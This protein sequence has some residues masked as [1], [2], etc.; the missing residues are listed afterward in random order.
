MAENC[1]KAADLVRVGDSSFKRGDYDEA[2]SSYSKAIR[3]CKASASKATRLVLAD[4]YNG[5]GHTLRSKGRFKEAYIS[6]KRALGIYTEGY[7]TGSNLDKRMAMA[8]HYTADVLADLNRIDES[9][10]LSRKELSIER[11]LYSHDRKNLFY[12]VYGLNNTACRFADKNDF[13]GAIRLLNESLKLQGRVASHDG[14]KDYPDLSWTYHI[15]GV[16]LLNMGDID[17]AIVTLRKSLGMRFVIADRNKR[18]IG[19][20]RNTLENLSIAYSRK[21][22]TQSKSGRGYL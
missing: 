18:F 15:L 14:K 21:G 9:L 4:A 13:K 8:L 17:G 16:T 22:A 2:V 10:R 12:L 19:A 7:R 20:L 5:M 1:A 11:R 3:I 6:N